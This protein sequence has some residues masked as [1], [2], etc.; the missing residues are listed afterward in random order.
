MQL[1]SPNL[2][3]KCFTMSPV[4]S[5]TSRSKVKVTSHKTGAGVS[6]CTLVSAGFFWAEAVLAIRPGSGVGRGLPKLVPGLPKQ[7]SA[8]HTPLLLANPKFARPFDWSTQ[9]KIPRIAPAFGL[10]LCCYALSSESYIEDQQSTSSKPFTNVK[11]T[12]RLVQTQT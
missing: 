5:F 12:S 8:P 7:H 9:I 6:L 2:K 10:Q 1:G 11:P 4:N 3:Y